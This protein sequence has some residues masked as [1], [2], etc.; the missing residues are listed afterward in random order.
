MAAVISEMLGANPAEQLKQETALPPDRIF[1]NTADQ[2]VYQTL[3]GAL[4]TGIDATPEHLAVASANTVE[5]PKTPKMLRV[6]FWIVIALS[7]GAIAAALTI[8]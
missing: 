5:E 2:A 7:A 8:I 3:Q 4:T 6:M 1:G